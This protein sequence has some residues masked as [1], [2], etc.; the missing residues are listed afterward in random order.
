MK[1]LNLKLIMLSLTVAI[2]TIVACNDEFLNTPP[3][4]ALDGSVLS[5][6][7]AGVDA[8]VISSHVVSESSSITGV[9]YLMSRAD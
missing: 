9:M 3:Q 8:T 5:T 1:K 2:V 6:S 4:G 7:R